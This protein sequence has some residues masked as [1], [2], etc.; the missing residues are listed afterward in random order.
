ML[1]LHVLIESNKKDFD[2]P[3]IYVYDIRQKSDLGHCDDTQIE[4]L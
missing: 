1:I 2:L 3:V 4:F